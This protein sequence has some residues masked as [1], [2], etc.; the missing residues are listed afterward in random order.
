[1]VYDRPILRYQVRE[2]FEGRL[3]V[4]PHLVEPQSYAIVL[5]ENS[6]RREAINRAILAVL[7]DPEWENLIRDYLGE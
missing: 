7:D 2:N 6:P 1:M 5:P 3:H 4:L